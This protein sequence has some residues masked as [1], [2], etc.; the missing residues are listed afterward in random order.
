MKLRLLRRLY[1]YY[2]MLLNKTGNLNEDRASFFGKKLLFLWS[3][4]IL[5]K[6][7]NTLPGNYYETHLPT[8]SS[9]KKKCAW[10]P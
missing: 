1:K 5:N 3:L 6:T 4:Q 7:Q 2:Y 10:L 8:K 9:Q